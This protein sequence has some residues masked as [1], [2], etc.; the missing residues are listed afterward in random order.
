L[1]LSG[2]SFLW[3]THATMYVYSGGEIYLNYWICTRYSHAQAGRGDTI[4]FWKDIW[5]GR[6]LRLTYPQLHSFSNNVNVTL[7]S[8][9]NQDELHNLFRL[10]LSEEAYLQ[11]CELEVYIQSLQDYNLA[12]QRKYISGNGQY[13]SLRAYKQL[14]GSQQIHP[15]YR[16]LWAS[17]C[18][19][20]H[21]VYIFLVAVINF[22]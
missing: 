3:A 18:Q 16:W 14:S 10:P 21:K 6:V 2:H 8:V 15:A 5:N 20:K 19:P 9:L 13:S 22:H 4:L 17:T 1:F 7:S 12:D 11:Y